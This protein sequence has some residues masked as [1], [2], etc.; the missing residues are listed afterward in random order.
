MSTAICRP[1]ASAVVCASVLRCESLSRCALVAASAAPA[2]TTTRA[3]AA[4]ATGVAEIMTSF[5]AGS[6]PTRGS[7]HRRRDEQPLPRVGPEDRRQRAAVT[8]LVLLAV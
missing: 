3:P 2:T 7:P 4:A 5:R 6:P 8:Q 1:A